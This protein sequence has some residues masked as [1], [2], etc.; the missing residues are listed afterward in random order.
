MKMDNYIRNLDMKSIVAS[1]IEADGF[2]RSF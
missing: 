1:K 2:Y